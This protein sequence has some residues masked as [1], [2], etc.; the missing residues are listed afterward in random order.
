MREQLLI[1]T[2][3]FNCIKKTLDVRAELGKKRGAPVQHLL[4]K[5]HPALLLP[6]PEGTKSQSCT[7]CNSLTVLLYLEAPWP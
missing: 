5:C 2:S 6:N 7:C 1:Y 4:L 3:G